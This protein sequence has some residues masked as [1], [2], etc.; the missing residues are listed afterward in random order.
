[1]HAFDIA[2]LWRF[3]Q[4]VAFSF[5]LL[6]HF[7]MVYLWFSV[8][9]KIV[10]AYSISFCHFTHNTIQHLKCVL[11]LGL[12]RFC[13]RSCQSFT[14]LFNDNVI[15]EFHF[16]ETHWN[17]IPY[18]VFMN[19]NTFISTIWFL[20]RM[21][22]HFLYYNISILMNS[23]YGWSFFPTNYQGKRQK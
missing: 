10:T 9:L 7:R 23:F 16:L 13:K 20:K 5:V 1:M 14:N 15:S 22:Y 12:Q 17:A 18:N 4:Y 3:Q 2:F 21:Q 19:E 8:S 11:G 6:L